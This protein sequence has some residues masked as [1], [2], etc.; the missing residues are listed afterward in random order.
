[1]PNSNKPDEAFI[2]GLGYVRSYA[3]VDSTKPTTPPIDPTVPSFQKSLMSDSVV[4]KHQAKQLE[5]VEA[6]D[7]KTHKVD[8]DTDELGE[9]DD[10]ENGGDTEM[11]EP[12]SE[13]TD[14]VE[15]TEGD[16]DTEMAEP[17]S[18]RTDKLK[19]SD[20][21]K[22][23]DHPGQKSAAIEPYE[24]E[25]RVYVHKSHAAGTVRRVTQNDGVLEYTVAL[26][27]GN[28]QRTGHA[29]IMPMTAVEASRR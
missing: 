9:G 25:T 28:V 8:E 13:R 4:V 26:D 22:G 29:D 1:M 11:A 20:A 21:P 7:V 10:E 18:K 6:S 14:D 23:P 12:N 27:N 16:A 3:N 19:A 2:P 5:A 15:D 24:R 17:S